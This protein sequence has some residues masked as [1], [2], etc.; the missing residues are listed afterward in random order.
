LTNVAN[1]M[2]GRTL[3]PLG[4]FATSPT[5]GSVKWFREEYERHV[6]EKGCWAKN[7]HSVH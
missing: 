4:D 6:K 2:T 1:Q 3:C 5:I 7:D